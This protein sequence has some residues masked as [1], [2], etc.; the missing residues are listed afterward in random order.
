MLN[1]P[2]KTFNAKGDGASENPSLAMKPCEK[3]S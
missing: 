2:G 1:E 3:L